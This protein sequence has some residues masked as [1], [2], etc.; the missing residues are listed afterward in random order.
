MISNL[1]QFVFLDP[2]KGHDDY[3]STDDDD[4]GNNDGGYSAVID[5]I[6][7]EIN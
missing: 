5:I 1:F 3:N 2:R 6:N 4:D 7:F